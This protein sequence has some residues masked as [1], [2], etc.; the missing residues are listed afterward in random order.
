MKLLES[1]LSVALVVALAGCDASVPS[2]VG[3]NSQDAGIEDHDHDHDRGDHAHD[4]HD[5]EGDGHPE[6][7]SQ[8]VDQIKEMGDKIITAFADGSPDDAHDELHEIGHVIERLPELATKASLTADQEQKVGE[9]TE[10]LMDAF[11]ELD[12]TLHGGEDVAV[13]E[14]SEKISTQ[15]KKLQ[16]ML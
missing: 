6:S 5:H 16:S 14:I 7:I 9:I 1:L 13:D 2:T 4:E 15:I 12:G 8:A 3:G 11:G 10:A